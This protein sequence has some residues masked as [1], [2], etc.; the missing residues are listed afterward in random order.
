MAHIASHFSNLVSTSSCLADIELE[1][2][3]PRDNS[4]LEDIS[5]LLSCSTPI[6][7]YRPNTS[8]RK[9]C[10][11]CRMASL[12]SCLRRRNTPPYS[13]PL[14]PLTLAIRNT[15][16]LYM[17]CNLSRF[18][19]RSLRC[20]FR[21]DTYTRCHT[22]CPL[23]SSCL[24]DRSLVSLSLARSSILLGMS[25]KPTDRLHFGTCLLD[26]LEAVHF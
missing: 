12:S 8:L 19:V 5:H 6:H 11:R 1:L 10:C 9:L 3:C 13:Y 23:D 21:S 22:E 18:V 24:L 7:R 15:Y 4:G 26:S 17:S 2:H 16:P 14:V 25:R 20:M